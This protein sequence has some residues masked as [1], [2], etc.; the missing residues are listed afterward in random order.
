VKRCAFGAKKNSIV[1]E[2]WQ[3]LLNSGI[4]KDVGIFVGAYATIQAVNRFRTRDVDPIFEEFPYLVGYGFVDVL[5][6][7]WAFNQPIVVTAILRS[8]D[9]FLKASANGN[10]RSDGFAINRQANS[11]IRQV[12]SLINNA[13]RS[14]SDTIALAA[15]DFERDDAPVLEGMIDTTVRNMLLGD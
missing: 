14:S 10:V 2:M 15:I 5:T 7:L 3:Q 6:P 12:E 13:K 9:S 4:A 1:I 11:I 8:I